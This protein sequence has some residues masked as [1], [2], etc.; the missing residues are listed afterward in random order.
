MLN[1]ASHTEA[2][3]L[4]DCSTQLYQWI[5]RNI[6]ERTSAE[7]QDPPSTQMHR[8]TAEQLLNREAER[9]VTQR[10]LPVAEV[11]TACLTWSRMHT[12]SHVACSAAHSHVQV[13]CKRWNMRSQQ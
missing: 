2:V 7:A 12:H 8:S 6:A 3:A 5:G 11:R 13:L 1:V 4:L 9:L 10:P